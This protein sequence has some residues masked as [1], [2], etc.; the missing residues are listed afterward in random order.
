MDNTSIIIKKILNKN[1]SEVKALIKSKK[2]INWSVPIDQVNGM[3]HHLAYHNQNDLIEAI[4]GSILKDLLIQENTEGDTV[5][6]IA[7]RLKNVKLLT[8]LIKIDTTGLYLRNQLGFSSMY[9]ILSDTN[10]VKQLTKLVSIK[11]HYVCSKFSLLQNYILENDMDMCKY[12]IDTLAK[13]LLDDDLFTLIESEIEIE[14]KLE[15]ITKMIET[16]ID[17][18]SKNHQFI[19]PFILATYL[20]S[21]QICDHLLILGTDINYYRPENNDN[22]LTICILNGNNDLIKLL[23]DHEIDIAVTDKFLKTPLHYLFSESIETTDS[24]LVSDTNKKRMLELCENIN[25]TDNNMDSILNLLIQ[26][27]DWKN[28]SQILEEK[29]M[30]IYLQNKDDL[31]PVD[32]VD[33]SDLDIFYQ[34]VYRSYLNQ[35]E[36]DIRFEDPLDTKVALMIEHGY[37]IKAFKE[38]IMRKI[39]NGESYPR[40]HKVK[41]LKWITPPRTNITHFSAYTYNYICFIYY[42]LNKY[43]QIK[44]PGITPNVMENKSLKDLY[45]EMIEDYVED[46]PDNAIFRS[47]IRDYINHSPILINHVIIWKN[48]QK[49]FFSPYIIQGIDAT[50]KSYPDTKFILFKLTIIS[51]KISITPIF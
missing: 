7:C 31:S 1:W 47:I 22:P 24:N 36:S 34:L 39:I 28:Y 12:L 48:G 41:N 15:L 5:F 16:G 6:H 43:P 50:I 18:N 11:D 20:N 14:H 9:Y 29:K 51:I 27:C 23:L 37:N 13:Q 3:I 46:T 32:A 25:A 19:T 42:I 38:Y 26:N 21:I 49:Y 4:D 8:F 44:I 30:K 45:D 35:L 2:N 10:V 33:P 17:I 40:E